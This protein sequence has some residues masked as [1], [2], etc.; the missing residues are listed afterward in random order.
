MTFCKEH[1]LDTAIIHPNFSSSH[2]ELVRI[3]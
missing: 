3:L 2:L 1:Y